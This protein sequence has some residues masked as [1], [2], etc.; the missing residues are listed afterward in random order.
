[1]NPLDRIIAFFAPKTALHRAHARRILSYYEIAKPSPYRKGRRSVG[2]GNESVAKAAESPRE[3]AR[4]LEE[5]HDLAI[6][7]LDVLV[8]N[9]V[10][11]AGVQVEPQPRHRDGSIH[12]ELARQILTLH[13]DWSKRP[14]VTWSHNWASAQRLLCRTWLRDGEVLAQRLLGTSPVL[15]HGTEIPYSVEMLE[16]DFMPMNYDDINRNIRMGVQRNQWNRPVRYLIYK[17]HPGDQ[18][19]YLTEADLKSVS[20]DR[21]L[22]LKLTNRI[23]QVRGVSIFATVMARLDD[24]KDYEESER[25]AAKVA[26][27]MAAFIIKGQPDMYT[28]DLDKEMRDI[29]FR[30]G[31]VFDDLEPG[32]S[33]G[34]IDTNR[35]NANLATYRQGQLRAIAAGTRITYSSAAKD[36]GGTY[37]SQ[38]QE[39]VEGYGAYGVLANE[40]IGQ[41]V[42]PVY[43]DMIDAAI[44]SGKLRIPRDVDPETIN[45]ALFIPPQM[46]WI[47]PQK[48]AV[49]L[50]TLENNVHASGPEIIRRRGQNPRDVLEQEAN[51]RRLLKEEGLATGSPAPADTGANDGEGENDAQ[52]RKRA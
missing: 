4:W 24:L 3:Q 14:E 33:V 52:A 23:N 28:G 37:S 8:Q 35:P 41:M 32:E 10:G 46:P 49:A 18:T 20:A 42:T 29:R 36:Y 31:M 47:D 21:M 38:R 34:T 48:E 2:S 50:E 25:V 1:M 51:W 12:D 16:P 40:F 17:K 11:P 43:E 15:D 45:D 5:N 19:T 39:L 27:S 26:A 22:H 9:V 7:V 13:R 30:P 6:G 44:L